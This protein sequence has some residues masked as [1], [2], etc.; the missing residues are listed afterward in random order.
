MATA[1][2]RSATERPRASS[3]WA[4]EQVVGRV[5]VLAQRSVELDDAG[6]GRH[7][8]GGVGATGCRRRSRIDDVGRG[9]EERVRA[10]PV[11]VG[12]ERD[13][14]VA[15]RRDGSRAIR[16]ERRPA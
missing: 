1:S 13:E 9:E 12:D 7:G 14:R 15:G 5:E 8:R 10:A 4:S 6:A 16:V 2:T 3:A 11:P